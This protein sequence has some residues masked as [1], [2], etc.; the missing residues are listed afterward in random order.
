MLP[1]QLSKNKENR[2]VRHMANLVGI[3]QLSSLEEYSKEL[4]GDERLCFQPFDIVCVEPSYTH[5]QKSNLAAVTFPISW[6]RL[7][8][9]RFI[10]AQIGFFS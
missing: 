10:G 8:V 7:S 4:A 5:S 1:H 9:N 6:M 3:E 2:L